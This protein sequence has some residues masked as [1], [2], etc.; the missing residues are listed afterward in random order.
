[1]DDHVHFAQ[2][3]RLER[4]VIVGEKVMAA[5]PPLGAGAHREVEPEMRIR[6]Q[7]NVKRWCSLDDM[8]RRNVLPG[9]RRGQRRTRTRAVDRLISSVPAEQTGREPSLAGFGMRVL[10]DYPP[11]TEPPGIVQRRVR[12]ARRAPTIVANRPEHAVFPPHGLRFEP[13]ARRTMRDLASTVVSGRPLRPAA[14]SA[15][16]TRAGARC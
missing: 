3:R 12:L 2:A 4:P 11:P 15:L 14:S 1:M 10:C 5:P 6:E 7:Q 13:C 16:P 9:K 8:H